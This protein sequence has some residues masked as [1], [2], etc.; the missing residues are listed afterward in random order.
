V[1][2]EL[3]SLLQE[4]AKLPLADADRLALRRLEAAMT[5]SDGLSPAFL[6]R[7]SRETLAAR[8]HAF[9]VSLRPYFA[10]D[11]RRVPASALQR[12]AAG[13]GASAFASSSRGE[14]VQGSE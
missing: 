6:S 3:L 5:P 7:A 10:D 14:R 9:L 1:V 8:V 11:G 4:A 2:H 12:R 13:G